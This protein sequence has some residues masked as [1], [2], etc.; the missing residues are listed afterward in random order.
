M[1]KIRSGM[2]K[3]RIR[4]KHPGSATLLCSHHRRQTSLAAVVPVSVT[5]DN[6]RT[7]SGVFRGK[8]RQ[9]LL[10]T[11]TSMTKIFQ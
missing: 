8:D 11:I 9:S 3:I 7:I 5:I 4:D 2:E 10:F 1:E 6:K